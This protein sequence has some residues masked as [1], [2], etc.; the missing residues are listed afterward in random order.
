MRESVRLNLR[1]SDE[2]CISGYR[3]MRLTSLT[4]LLYFIFGL[5]LIYFNDENCMIIAI[6]PA[7][8]VLANFSS[9][10]ETFGS[11]DCQAYEETV[12]EANKETFR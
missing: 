2:M 1:V 6:D 10:S 7:I 4:H 8:F 12:K 9:N 11:T 3:N 5:D